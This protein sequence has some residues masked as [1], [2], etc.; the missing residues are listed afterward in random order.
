[1][2]LSSSF[3]GYCPRRTWLIGLRQ[4]AGW[5]LKVYAISA[6]GR[7]LSPV[8]TD[9]ALAYARTRLPDAPSAAAPGSPSY[10]FLILHEGTEAVWALF[11]LWFD[12]ILQQLVFKAD[13]DQPERFE[14][15]PFAGTAVCVWELEVVRFERDAWVRHVLAAP[16]APDFEQY[17]VDALTI[18][19]CDEATEPSSVKL[20]R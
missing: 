7:D 20:R 9:T 16:D 3:E 6:T 14:K 2:T 19:G 11:D 10:G 12:D 5:T 1:M 13:L 18:S 4:L 8:V 15:A 17:L